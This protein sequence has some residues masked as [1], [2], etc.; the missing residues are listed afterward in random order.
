[1]GVDEVAGDQIVVG[2][3]PRIAQGERRILHRAADRAPDIDD[4]EAVLPEQFLGLGAKM[5]AHPPRRRIH[6]VVVVH[7][8]R[9]RAAMPGRVALRT[10]WSKTTT[11]PAPRVSRTRR[12]TSG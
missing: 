8:P 4:A 5:V 3:A 2:A 12:S 10:L 1:M 11:R 9:R 6:R 7:L